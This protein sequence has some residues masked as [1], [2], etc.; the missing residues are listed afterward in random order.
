MLSIRNTS[1]LG[2]GFSDHHKGY[3]NESIWNG[4]LTLNRV[5]PRRV[6]DS[7]V[8][9]SWTEE[10]D[11]RMLAASFANRFKKS[12]IS[13]A[14]R[15]QLEAGGNRTRARIAIRCGVSLGLSV[16]QTM[17][18][19]IAC[20]AVHNASLLLDD[21]QDRDRTRRGRSAVWY[22][23]GPEIATLAS[24]VLV[25]GAFACLSDPAHFEFT[26]ELISLFHSRVAT[27]IY[28][29]EIDL[30]P[31]C[32]D[33]SNATENSSWLQYVRSAVAKS[34]GLLSLPLELPLLATNY[35]S[36]IEFAQRAMSHFATAYQIV[37]DLSD[38]ER[39]LSREGRASAPN[40]ISILSGQVGSQNARQ[41]AV[42]LV[43]AEIDLALDFAKQLPPSCLAVIVDEGEKILKKANRA[44]N[45]D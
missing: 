17:P 24:Q 8:E 12:N 25:S 2:S 11:Q 33:S 43:R 10:I 30:Y 36:E 27:T 29:Q 3:G 19:A 31:S 20:E 28:G 34:G 45:H 15:Y 44:I 22:R 6:D 37:D 41:S 42:N 23:Y 38:V 35:A 9:L 16:G 5:D 4:E 26:G 14:I 13:E 39:D 21:L 40:A 1:D 7:A 18:M 32:H